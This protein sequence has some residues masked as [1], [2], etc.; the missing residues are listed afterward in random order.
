MLKLCDDIDLLAMMLCDGELADQ[1]LRDVELH[2]LECAACR[3][4]AERERQV[5][6][7]LRGRLAAPAA[8]EL[9]RARINRALDDA[10]RARRRGAW[11]RWVLPGTA[12]AA[13]AA[14]LALFALSGDAGQQPTAPGRGKATLAAMPG[15]MRQVQ[16]GGGATGTT[17]S[18]VTFRLTGTES[19]GRDA[20]AMH[21]AIV[22]DGTTY[23]LRVV[24]HDANALE[25]DPRARRVVGGYEV[26][27][28]ALADA[29]LVVRDGARAL[30]MSSTTLTV[31][32]LKQ[33][34]GGTSIVAR[35]GADDPRR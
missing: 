8:P 25:V 7:E 18:D 23:D 22:A 21:Y 14:A 31:A 19:Y 12:A 5:L 30:R 9:L 11:R 28:S 13:A 35:I 1:E 6:G 3:A 34:I 32:D 24:I 26:W 2:L 29:G 20:V 10:D 27:D 33:L 16:A 15:G 17:I 4:H